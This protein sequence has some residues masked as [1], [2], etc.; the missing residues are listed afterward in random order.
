[1]TAAA[2]RQLLTP[3]VRATLAKCRRGAY[4]PEALSSAGVPG[5]LVRVLIVPDHAPAERARVALDSRKRI[6]TTRYVW[7][8][9]INNYLKGWE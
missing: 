7:A 6:D 5:D 3:P 1:M 8:A 9:D 4:L 2:A